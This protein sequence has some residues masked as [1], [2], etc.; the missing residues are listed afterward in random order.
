M[1]EGEQELCPG[2]VPLQLTCT[3]PGPCF[4]MTLGEGLRACPVP[5]APVLHR[6]AKSREILGGNR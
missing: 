2:C 4:W 6:C 5:R 3:G 1:Q